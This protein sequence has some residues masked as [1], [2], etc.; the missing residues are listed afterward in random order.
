[1]KKKPKHKPP[2]E[3][4]RL[5]NLIAQCM[6]SPEHGPS[7]HEWEKRI[8]NNL[9][10]SADRDTL[11]EVQILRRMWHDLKTGQARR[12]LNRMIS[13]GYIRPL[14]TDD[15]DLHKDILKEAIINARNLHKGNTHDIAK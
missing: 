5:I 6:F 15:F 7:I 4:D 1:M 2:R 9:R 3:T 14:S 8:R 13:K 12:D 10:L 11:S